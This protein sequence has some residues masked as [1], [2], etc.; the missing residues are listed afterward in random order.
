MFLNSELQKMR[1][2]FYKY[3]I[4]LKQNENQKQHTPE[5][6]EYEITILDNYGMIALKVSNIKYKKIKRIFDLTCENGLLNKNKF[7]KMIGRLDRAR[8]N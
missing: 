4:R 7:K 6:T 5:N 3:D 2:V 8:K 1:K